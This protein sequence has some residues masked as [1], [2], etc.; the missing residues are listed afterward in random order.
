MIG[1]Q[2]LGRSSAQAIVAAFKSDKFFRNSS[3]TMTTSINHKTTSAAH[4]PWSAKKNESG[5][6]SKRTVSSLDIEKLS[7]LKN[8][9]QSKM[10]WLK[11]KVTAMKKPTDHP[12]SA[13]NKADSDRQSSIA[14]SIDPRFYGDDWSSEEEQEEEEEVEERRELS[15]EEELKDGDDEPRLVTKNKYGM[16]RFLTFV[17]S[18]SQQCLRSFQMA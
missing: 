7:Q 13:R 2:T 5:G 12:V 14:E 9:I 6:G 4:E 8:G 17:L 10:D 16:C 3:N 11:Q 18:P 15:M 1:T